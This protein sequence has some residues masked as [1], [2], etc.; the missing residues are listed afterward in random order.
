M[1]LG[2][3]ILDPVIKDGGCG[4]SIAVEDFLEVVP[5]LPAYELDNGMVLLGG[6]VVVQSHGCL[7][8]I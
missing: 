1:R 3:L 8:T 7:I 4:G 6:S 2:Q 5:L